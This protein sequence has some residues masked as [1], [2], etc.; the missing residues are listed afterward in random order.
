M[1]RARLLKPGF[2]KNEFLVQ[3]SPYARLLFAGL[4]LL[5]DRRGRLEDRPLK[6]KA[7]L[8]PFEAIDIEPLLNELADSSGRFITR[9]QIEGEKF[10]QIENFHKHQKPHIREA[11]SEI[12]PCPISKANLGDAE[13][14]PRQCLSTTKAMP[15]PALTLNP[16][17][18][19]SNLQSEPIG[20]GVS[21]IGLENEID[22][23]Q[24]LAQEGMLYLASLNSPNHQNTGWIQGFLKIQLQELA[25]TKPDIPKP[26]ILRLW[27]DTCDLAVSKNATAPQWFKTTLKNKLE[28][29]VAEV[30]KTHVLDDLSSQSE[31]LLKFPFIRHK[32]TPEW[33]RSEE[34]EIRPESPSGLSHKKTFDYYPVAHLEGCHEEPSNA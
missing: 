4:W 1:A 16:L 12:P 27:R 2:Y 18:L 34:L 19:N 26:E 21:V 33:F 31:A 6:I 17:T 3:V 14:Q 10:I 20:S 15:S 32:Y 30:P 24:A 29:W 13:A 22:P 25:K 8:F 28:A 5:A 7:E 23:N 11:E 9:Y